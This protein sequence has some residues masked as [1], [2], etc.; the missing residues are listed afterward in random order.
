MTTIVRNIN[1]SVLNQEKMDMIHEKS[2]YLLE[3]V[4]MKMAGDRTLEKL[5]EKGAIIEGDLVKFPRSVVEE[6]LRTVPKEVTLYTRDG[7][8]NM[9]IDSKNNVYFG[10][11][12]DQLEILDYKTNKARTYLKEDIKTMCKIGDFLPNISFI[13]SVG[14]CGDVDPAVQ[15]QITFI[16]TVKNFSKTIN[17]STNDIESLQEII[18]M[19]AIVA[20]GHD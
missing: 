4:G 15:S 8:P 3:T 20:G 14:M 11:H 9:V 19:A 16:E 18:D 2:M 6:A 13:L 12:S 1:F 7:Q 17:F 10:T 5:R